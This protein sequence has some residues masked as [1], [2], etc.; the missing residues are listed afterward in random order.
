MQVF[1]DRQTICWLFTMNTH[2]AEI[3]HIKGY[4]SWKFVCLFSNW[5]KTTFQPPLI[6]SAKLPKE[7]PAPLEAAEVMKIGFPRYNN[8]WMSR[9]CKFRGAF[10][11]L[12]LST[13]LVGLT[14]KIH[15]LQTTRSHQNW[16]FTPL[17]SHQLW[18]ASD[19]QAWRRRKNYKPVLPGSLASRK[20]G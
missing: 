19:F 1:V 14:F 4:F 12:A 11:F 15:S 3:N 13:F 17:T 9:F 7:V 8:M 6:N 18:I 2:W 16:Y 5:S 20:P 10:K